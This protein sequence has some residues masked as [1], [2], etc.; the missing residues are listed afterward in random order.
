MSATTQALDAYRD[1]VEKRFYWTHN[2]TYRDG[3]LERALADEKVA[4]AA[5]VALMSAK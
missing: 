5:L 2:G 3:N 1:A 4:R